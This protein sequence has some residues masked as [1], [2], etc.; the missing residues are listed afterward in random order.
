M[1]PVPAYFV[2]GDD[3]QSAVLRGAVLNTLHL[4]CRDLLA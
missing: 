1:A 2:I 3:D 4:I